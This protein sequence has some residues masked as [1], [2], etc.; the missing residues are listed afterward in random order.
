[1]IVSA[2]L[3][4]DPAWRNKG[5]EGQKHVHAHISKNNNEKAKQARKHAH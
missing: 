3:W 5:M 2:N 4:S 1:M